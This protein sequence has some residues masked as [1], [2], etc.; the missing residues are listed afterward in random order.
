M[1]GVYSDSFGH[2]LTVWW[3]WGYGLFGGKN[4]MGEV[5]IQQKWGYLKHPKE[6]Q[7][8]KGAES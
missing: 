7:T 6:N 8:E 4:I 2:H 1:L 3:K 5:E